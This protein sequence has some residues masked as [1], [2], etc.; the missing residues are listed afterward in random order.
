MILGFGYGWIFHYILGGMRLEL[1]VRILKW[2]FAW[3]HDF[4]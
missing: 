2:H 1:K 3:V 4:K